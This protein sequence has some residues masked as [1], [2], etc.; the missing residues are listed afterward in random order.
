M[1]ARMRLLGGE[2]CVGRRR[3]EARG[4]ALNERAPFAGR[5]HP[6]D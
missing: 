6:V 2:L 4:E 3:G 1:T 5:V